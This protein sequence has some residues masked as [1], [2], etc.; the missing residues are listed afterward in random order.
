MKRRKRISKKSKILDKKLIF[1]IAIIAIVVGGLVCYKVFFQNSP[2]IKFSLRAAIIDQL[3]KDIPNSEFNSTVA[4]LLVRGGFP[5]TSVF[6]HRS[7][8]V[9]VDFYG[10]LANYNYGIIILRAHSALREGQTTVDLFT[11]ENYTDALANEYSHKYGSKL[12]VRG[13]YLWHPGEFYFAITSDFIESLNGYF[14]KSIVIAMGCWSIRPS[15][16][17]WRWMAEAFI[18]KGAKAYIGWTDIVYPQDTDNE[19][20]SLLNMLLIENKPLGDAISKT[21]SYQTQFENQTFTTHLDFYPK[22]G[23]N[24]A[25]NLTISD[26]VKDVKP[27][28]TLQSIANNFKLLSPLPFIAKVIYYKSKDFAICQEN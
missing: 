23:P 9:T 28:Q 27:S 7:E 26:L 22:S 20:I 5:A 25:V 3:G 17:G 18:E 6:Y 15:E 21:R 11:S 12:L 13:E 24:S 1:S 19:T 16:P 10:G 2:E 14:P 8:D 4:D